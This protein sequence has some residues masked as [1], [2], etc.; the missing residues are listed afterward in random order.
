MSSRH[1][2]SAYGARAQEYAEVLGSMKATAQEDRELIVRWARECRGRIVD[3]GCGPGH[4]T[5]FL[6]DLGL[7][8]EGVDPVDAFISIARRHH[9]HVSYQQGSFASLPA[10]RYGA[11]LAWYSLIH[12]PPRDLPE[13][14]ASL[15]G[16][17]TPQGNLLIGFFAGNRVE[18]F[19]HAVAPAYYWP[20]QTMASLL[21]DTGFSILDIRHRK[22][23]GARDHGS[24][25]CRAF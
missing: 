6:H 8:V 15:K 17:L 3:A 23:P 9:P 19:P 12:T 5:A 16:S 11:A 7:D 14:L 20:P 18:E 21:E 25:S 1:V 10:A 4:W 22:V 2:W 13:T 24:I